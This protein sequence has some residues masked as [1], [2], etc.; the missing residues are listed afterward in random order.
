M[1]AAEYIAAVRR[2]AEKIWI[3]VVY[4][5]CGGVDDFAEA[6]TILDTCAALAENPAVEGIRI[7]AR[8]AWSWYR[9]DHPT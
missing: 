8:G 6:E 5:G 3:V 7:N 1:S 9:E 4:T 2:E